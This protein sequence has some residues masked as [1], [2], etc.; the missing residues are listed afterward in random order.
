MIKSFGD[1]LVASLQRQQSLPS[2]KTEKLAKTLS[3][4]SVNPKQALTM[5]DKISK[6]LTK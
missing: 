4:G 2:A 1:I 6:G 5:A 3:S